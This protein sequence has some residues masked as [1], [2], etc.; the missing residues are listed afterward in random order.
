MP[1][2]DGDE[3]DSLGVVT[4]LL[5]ELG[6]FL[7]DFIETVLAP[8]H[9]IVKFVLPQEYVCHTLVVSIL[10]TATIS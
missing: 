4:D 1:A 10:L 9:N 2:R 5:D 8:L 7:D 6:R 3:C